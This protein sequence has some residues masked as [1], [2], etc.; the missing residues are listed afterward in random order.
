MADPLD[1]EVKTMRDKL[2]N[3]QHYSISLP[4]KMKSIAKIRNI[5]FG[6]IVLVTLTLG[7]LYTLKH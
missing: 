4:Q 6:I 5:T 3:R 7:I 2:N 1:A